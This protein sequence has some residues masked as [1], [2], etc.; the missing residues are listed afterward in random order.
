MRGV[1]VSQSLDTFRLAPKNSGRTRSGVLIFPPRSCRG[2]R[3]A[4]CIESRADLGH[5]HSRWKVARGPSI[6]FGWRRNTRDERGRGFDL[7]HPFMPSATRS[8]SDRM[9]FDT[10]RRSRLQAPVR[11]KGEKQWHRR[12]WFTRRSE[13]H[14]SELQS[15][16]SNSYAVI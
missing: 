12:K 10:L 11:S 14:T 15:L 9:I 6:R 7:L 2:P 4:W 13:E 16:M 8:Q 1:S 3:V 5:Q